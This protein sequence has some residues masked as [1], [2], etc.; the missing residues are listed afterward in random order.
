MDTRFGGFEG[1]IVAGG[2]GG[3]SHAMYGR[4]R[5]R[6]TTVH[7]AATQEQGSADLRET[8]WLAAE[9]GAS[10]AMRSAVDVAVQ[11]RFMGVLRTM[12]VIR[13]VALYTEGQTPKIKTR[14]L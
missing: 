11:P 4:G 7:G 14:P 10:H 5:G 12:T 3:A 1:N 2:R 9:R 6:T 13:S 8:A